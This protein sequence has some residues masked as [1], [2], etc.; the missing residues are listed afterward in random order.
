MADSYIKDITAVTEPIGTD[1]VVVERDPS[2]TNVT[3]TI[4]VDN[5]MKGMGDGIYPGG[6]LTLTSG[7][8]LSVS[9]TT[10]TS[11]YY[12]PFMHNKIPLWNGAD[13]IAVTF[14]EYTLALGT[15]TASLPYD[16]FAY[17]N[18]GSLAIEKTAWTNATTRATA[19]SLQDGRYCKTGDKTRLYLG[20]FYSSSTTQTTDAVATRYLYNYYHKKMLKLKKTDTT[21]SWTYSTASWRSWNNSTANRVALMVGVQEDL[22]EITFNGVASNSAGYSMGHGVGLDSTSANSADTYTAAGSSGALVAGSAVYKGYIG[23]GFHYLQALEYGGASGTTTFY[24]DA[25]VSYVQSG[26]VG[27]CMG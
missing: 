4:S 27:W 2:G 21:D 26:I 8:P 9:D 19:I 15:M 14:T 6:R 3:K 11:I 22:T 23:V 5:L 10:A 16:V 25:G 20:S 17:Y 12:T 1:L 24:G 13:W 7:S 18:S